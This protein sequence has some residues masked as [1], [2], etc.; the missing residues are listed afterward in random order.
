M[1][2]NDEELKAQ[3][4]AT[5]EDVIKRLL[6]GAREKD[7]LMLS[8]I[9]HLVRQAGQDM[10][11]EMTGVLASAE[12]QG[13]E[14]RICP[15]CGGKMRYKGLKKRDVVTETGEMSLERA[16]YYCPTCQEDIFPPRPTLG[17]E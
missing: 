3:M 7:E 17:A 11:Q 14:N 12:A 5:A 10:M 13:Q 1:R 8:D 9:E 16:Y 15:V 2:P 6:A 4:M